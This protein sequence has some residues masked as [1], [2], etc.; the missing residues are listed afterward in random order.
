MQCGKALGT[1]PAPVACASYTKQ[2]RSKPLRWPTP[3]APLP[4]PTKVD[5]A[6]VDELEGRLRAINALATMTRA[7]RSSVPLDYVL[8]IGG[9]DLDKVEAQVRERPPGS[10]SAKLLGSCRT[11]SCCPREAALHKAGGNLLWAAVVR[12]TVQ[13]ETAA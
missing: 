13:R 8:G 4:T 11:G 2:G 5:E 3:L 12:E 6:A 7:T 9:F 10:C 1:G